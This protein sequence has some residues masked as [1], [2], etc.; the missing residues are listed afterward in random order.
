MGPFLTEHETAVVALFFKGYGIRSRGVRTRMAM[1][2]VYILTGMPGA[3]KEEFVKVAVEQGYRVVRMGDVVRQEAIRR[4]VNMDDRGVGGFASEERRIEGAG[5]WAHRCIPLLED[6]DFVI[7]GSRSV[8]EL[9][10]FRG[11]LGDRVRLVAIY[12]SPEKRFERL[13]RRN[14]SD[15]PQTWEAFRERDAREIGWGLGELIDRADIVLTNEGALE[16]FHAKV[17][18]ELGRPW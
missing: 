17:R 18:E 13:K 9:E 6:H 12:A 10:V 7:D 5:I 3:G 2:R 4:N 1:A 14:R 16:E 11:E 15:A 8:H